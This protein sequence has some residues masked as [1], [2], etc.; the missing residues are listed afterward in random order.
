MAAAVMANKAAVERRS[1]VIW[2]PQG[3]AIEVEARCEFGCSE[4]TTPSTEVLRAEYYAKP[5]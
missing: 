1:L 5:M 4:T 3:D 2:D